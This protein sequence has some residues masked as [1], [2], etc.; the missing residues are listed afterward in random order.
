[1]TGISL[2]C[3]ADIELQPDPHQYRY[4][5]ALLTN[6][7]SAMARGEIDRAEWRVSLV[8]QLL[9]KLAAIA[10]AEVGAA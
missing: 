4:M 10:K 9:G 5:R 6:A 2:I 1:M 8:N 3:A 7:A